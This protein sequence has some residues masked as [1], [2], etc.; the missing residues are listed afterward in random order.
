MQKGFKTPMM[1][2]VSCSEQAMFEFD[3]S[4]F[5]EDTAPLQ[6][7]GAGNGD[8]IYFLLHL[9]LL[10]YDDVMIH[11]I[12][13][14]IIIIIQWPLP[15]GGAPH[16]RWEIHLSDCFKLHSSL[17]CRVYIE[18]GRFWNK[19][20]L[21]TICQCFG[22]YISPNSLPVLLGPNY[23][24]S[25]QYG[26]ACL[27]LNAIITIK[28]LLC[29]LERQQEFWLVKNPINSELVHAALSD[30]LVPQVNI[31]DPWEKFSFNIFLL[32]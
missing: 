16:N 32:Y 15:W 31:W 12:T 29:W 28:A 5:Y 2:S 8:H 25:W 19:G 14:I 26:I 9:H 23:L 10:Y 20:S 3:L 7:S 6:C 4:I 24:W 1:D 18:M 13:P 17:P 27:V 30:C 11:I 21:I 22:G